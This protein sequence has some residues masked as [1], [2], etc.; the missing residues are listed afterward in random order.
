MKPLPVEA[1]EAANGANIIVGTLQRVTKM[2]KIRRVRVQYLWINSLSNILK[3]NG[4]GKVNHTQIYELF[5][6]IEGLE[7]YY[8]HYHRNNLDIVYIS[9]H[10]EEILSQVATQRLTQSPL[11]FKFDYSEI[12]TQTSIP[13][14][15]F[16]RCKNRVKT[17]R[18]LLTDNVGTSGKTIYIFTLNFL[19]KVRKALKN[20]Q[21]QEL[22]NT[23]IFLSEESVPTKEIDLWINVEYPGLVAF[24]QQL[25]SLPST[26]TIL[27]L[28]KDEN[29]KDLTTLKYFL[30]NFTEVDLGLN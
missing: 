25:N 7:E 19:K 29:P 14:L 13:N 1:F 30:R 17:L 22:L 20:S 11:I 28:I 9:D 4:P 12:S 21:L 18:W 23:S 24:H 16:F 6:I 15:Q 26:S 5:K 2:M 27:T 10:N 8:N 3:K